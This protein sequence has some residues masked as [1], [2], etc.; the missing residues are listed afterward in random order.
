MNKLELYN[1]IERQLG[2]SCFT[3]WEAFQYNIH[4]EPSNSVY[5]QEPADPSWHTVSLYTSLA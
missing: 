3:T 5:I 2:E 1:E 4:R